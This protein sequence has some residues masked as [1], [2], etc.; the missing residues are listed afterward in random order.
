[1][2]SRLLLVHIYYYA[3]LWR[4]GGILLCTCRSVG[5]SVDKPCPIYNWRTHSPRN[6]KLSMVVGHDQQ[7]NSFEFEVSRS[8]LKVTVTFQL[9]GIHVSQTFLVTLLAWCPLKM[10]RSHGVST[11]IFT[12]D[13]FFVISTEKYPKDIK[14]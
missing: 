2:P 14:I 13:V 8:K 4:S 9:G 12:G 10:S 3:P 6:F 11:L 1:M 7:M 5:Q